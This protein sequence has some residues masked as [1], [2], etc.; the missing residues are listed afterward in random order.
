M[1]EYE[2]QYAPK[3]KL[4][5]GLQRSAFNPCMILKLPRSVTPSTLEGQVH[6]F[7]GFMNRPIEYMQIQVTI[8]LYSIPLPISFKILRVI[9]NVDLRKLFI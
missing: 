5:K 6:N 3:P 4:S 8:S 7:S 1:L 9:H 2:S